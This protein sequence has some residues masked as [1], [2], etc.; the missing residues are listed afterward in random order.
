MTSRRRLLPVLAAA[1]ITLGAC[2]SPTAAPGS[3]DRPDWVLPEG[4]GI[5]V[6]SAD[7]D[8]SLELHSDPQCPW[9]A[10]FEDKV[11][12]QVAEIVDSGEASLTLVLRS[13]LDERAGS[14]ASL[15]A[16]SAVLCSPDSDTALDYF[17]AMMAA[18]E[19][20]EQP[21]DRDGLV[22]VVEEAGMDAGALE[23]CLDSGH[24]KAW[25]EEMEATAIADGVQGTPRL[26]INDRQVP[27]ELMG[28]MLEEQVTLDDLVEVVRQQG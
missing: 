19:A 18:Q 25:A 17:R 6:G 27:Q 13:F 11:G 8:I 16:D 28:P 1:M 26:F 20:S 14:D 3:T 24:T 2:S 7:A 23:Q 12:P 5:L 22:E 10:R 4:A 21:L 15:L 9:C